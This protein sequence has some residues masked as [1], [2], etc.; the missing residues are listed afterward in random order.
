MKLDENGQFTPKQNVL[1]IDTGTVMTPGLP[2]QKVMSN[3]KVPQFTSEIVRKPNQDQPSK[4]F[5]VNL[6]S[7][8][9][10]ED[11]DIDDVN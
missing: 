10:V 11:M 1:S 5:A 9:G 6:N 3:L 4:A 8:W 2:E 7:F